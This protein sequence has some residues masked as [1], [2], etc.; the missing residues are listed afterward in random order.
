VLSYAGRISVVQ[1]LP[2]L[3]F[4]DSCLAHES[5]RRM[6]RHAAWLTE[7]FHSSFHRR[8]VSFAHIAVTAGSNQVF[9]R[10][11]SASSARNHVL[12]FQFAAQEP[13]AAILANVAVTDEDVLSR[14]GLDPS[15]QTPILAQANDA[16]QL[17]SDMHK[18]LV[19]LLDNSDAFDQ[20]YEGATC[21]SDIHGLVARIKH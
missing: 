11:Q 17:Q 10:T 1:I 8:P 4:A 12:E 5:A 9:P 7:Q 14:Q 18:S 3:L 15:R 6:N 16:R 13:L 2:P 19:C 21:P 20:Q